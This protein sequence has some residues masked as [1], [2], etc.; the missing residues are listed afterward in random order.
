MAPPVVSNAG[1]ATRG[2]PIVQ[3]RCVEQK[4]SGNRGGGHEGR[5]DRA[6]RTPPNF[7]G[8]PG[9]GSISGSQHVHPSCGCGYHNPVWDASQTKV[10][11]QDSTTLKGLS[12]AERSG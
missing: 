11:V 8:P 1:D 7:S 3:G 4:A 5:S 6:P 12:F 10:V 9:I 2:P